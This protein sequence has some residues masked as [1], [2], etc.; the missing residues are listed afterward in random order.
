MQLGQHLTNRLTRGTSTNNIRKT[1]T[2]QGWNLYKDKRIPRARTR[3]RSILATL[4]VVFSLYRL[5]ALQIRSPYCISV[6]CVGWLA[7]WL[8]TDFEDTDSVE[9]PLPRNNTSL[10]SFWH[11][12]LHSICRLRNW[13]SIFMSRHTEL[14]LSVRPSHALCFFVLA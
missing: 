11:K 10:L 5:F 1:P 9:H 2:M 14:P 6:W 12:Y 8:K 4:Y 7:K 3:P 13:I